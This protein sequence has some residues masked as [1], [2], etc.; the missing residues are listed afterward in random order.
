MDVGLWCDA[1]Y[2]EWL[3]V[4]HDIREI[5]ETVEMGE[6]TTISTHK[7]V[8]MRVAM[9][10]GDDE[11]MGVIQNVA[12]VPGTMKNLISVSCLRKRGLKIKTIDNPIKPNQRM[13]SL[14]H[15]PTRGIVS[16][17]IKHLYGL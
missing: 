9:K 12:F 6:G 17:G 11:N 10:V 15:N 2:Y 3:G 16:R 14:V 4:L 13:A 7:V 5:K 1:S 8:S